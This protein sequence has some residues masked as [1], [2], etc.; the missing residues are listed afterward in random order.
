VPDL[1][2]A[3]SKHN[4]KAISRLELQAEIT[5]RVRQANP[6]C[7]HFGGVFVEGS[8]PKSADESNWTILGVKYG[9]SDRDSVGAV[10]EIIVKQMQR[11]FFLSGEHPKSAK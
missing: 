6:G 2:F 1:K 4:R 5:T 7:E 11:E 9:R 10:L 8:T 3:K